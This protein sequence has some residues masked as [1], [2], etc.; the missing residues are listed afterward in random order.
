VKDVKEFAVSES[1]QK[2]IFTV[3]NHILC[4]QGHPEYKPYHITNIILPRLLSVNKIDERVKK[5]VEL[6]MIAAK[7]GGESELEKW[8]KDKLFF[9]KLVHSFLNGL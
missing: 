7:G 8:H 5:K 1:C 4:I 9:Q 6:E 2:E 3:G